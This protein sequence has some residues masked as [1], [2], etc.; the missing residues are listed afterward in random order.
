MNQ[1]FLPVSLCATKFYSQG[2][3][4]NE[5]LK[6]SHSL[7]S[8]HSLSTDVADQTSSGQRG[9]SSPFVG[10]L[11]QCGS[12]SD[13]LDL[14]CKYAPTTRQVSNCLTHMWFSMKKMTDEQRR[15]EL[16]LMF[17]HPE[18]EPLLQRA[19][20]SI[21]HMRNQDVAYSL[22][23]MVN[24]GVPQRSRVIQ[25]FL[26]TCQERLND[27]DEK[28]LS[29]LASALD[30]MKGSQNADAL[31][32]GVRLIVE[33]RLPEIK[34]VLALQTMMRLLGRDAPKKLK[35]KLEA[36]L[37]FTTFSFPIFL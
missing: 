15:Y 22:L 13:V 5:D 10:L 31:K 16:Q 17:E 26:R 24:L 23:S 9:R 21:Q 8:D 1:N 33:V 34:N 3:N 12:P 28:T 14:T 30:Q 11:R 29:I 20:R 27:L 6:Q 7:T 19:M 35:E 32:E 25:T 4:H 2:G 37:S 36:R 18:F